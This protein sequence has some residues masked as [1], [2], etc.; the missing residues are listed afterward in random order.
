MPATFIFYN[1]CTHKLT[2]LRNGPTIYIK[3]TVSSLNINLIKQGEQDSIAGQ[4]INF[5]NVINPEKSSPFIWVLS[6]PFLYSKTNT[7]FFFP[8]II[9]SYTSNTK[10]KKSILKK[11]K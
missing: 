8:R 4:F 9:Y 1:D 7:T 3:Q 2:L 6:D 5:L 11:L 10:P